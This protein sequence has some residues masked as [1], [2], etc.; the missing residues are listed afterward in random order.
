MRLPNALSRNFGRIR[1]LLSESDDRSLKQKVIA[2]GLLSTGVFGA[3][4]V[5]R[6]GST[7][8]LTRLLAPETFGIFAAV[9]GIIFIL[10]MFSDLGLRA[11][12]LTQEDE[13][14]EDF[15]FACFTMQILRGVL[16]GLVL[17]AMAG[18]IA[19]LQSVAAFPPDSSYMAPDLPAVL[20]VVALSVVLNGFGSLNLYVHQRRMALTRTALME[21][22]HAL[23]SFVVV[24]GLTLWL[25]SIWGLAIAQVINTAAL[26]LLTYMLFSGPMMRL[27]WNRAH[28]WTILMRGKW[29]MGQSGLSGL[30]KMA[31]RILLG[32]FLPAAG[33]GHY[34]LARQFFEIADQF[35]RQMH[36][37]MGMQVFTALQ[38]DA[39]A[40]SFTRRYYRYRVP[41]DAVAMLL[42]GM[43]LTTAPLL[44]EILYDDRYAPVAPV[45]Q[46][47]ALGLPLVGPSL[48]SAAI[49]AQRRFRL[50][51]A[52]RLVSAVTIWVGLYVTLAIFNDPIAAFAVIALHPLPELALLMI[53]GKRHQW[54]IL[55]KEIRLLPLVAVGAGAGLLITYLWQLV[56]G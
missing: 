10:H 22:V 26:V 17:A 36:T 11:L 16:I 4:I 24:I 2:S 40:G 12:I 3:R 27:G 19:Y 34:Y 53:I 29:I 6:L 43:F 50:N 20:V 5:L 18:I 54:V 37:R 48:L 38:K 46:I 7:I 33:F 49:N 9:L 1:G 15:L 14:D 47:L 21:I 52:L 13:A 31:D 56:I 51:A 28:L 44:V 32:L 39:D 30:T 45:L 8:I 41:F 42:G 55:W 23:T 35:L 25:Q